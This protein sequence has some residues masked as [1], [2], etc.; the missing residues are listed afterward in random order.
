[1]GVV[2]ERWMDMFAYT[3]ALRIHNYSYINN[4]SSFP[5][6]HNSDPLVMQVA[7]LL[8]ENI[9]MDRPI[10]YSLLIVK[11]EEHLKAISFY[12]HPIN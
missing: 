6:M 7:Y 8:G 9:N 2:S 1:M 10:K 12:N 11:R 3:R 4:K 5:L